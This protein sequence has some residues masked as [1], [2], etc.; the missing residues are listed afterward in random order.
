MTPSEI[1]A[2]AK[3][4]WL[5]TF[6]KAKRS[7]QYD[8]NFVTYIES[9]ENAAKQEVIEHLQPWLHIL[10]DSIQWLANL[11]GILNRMNSEKKLDSA[12]QSIW[13]LIGASCAHAVAVRR[14]VLSGLDTSARAI[15]R[16]L[17][18]HLCASLVF[19]HK[20]E[21]GAQFHQCAD[22][23]TAAQFWYKHL[24][25]RALKKHLNAIE[26]SVGLDLGF[27][28]E[29]R[30][31]R[32]REIESFSQAIH[33]SY[34][35]AAFSTITM[36]PSD[37]D[38]VGPAFVGMASINSKRTL[39][40]S[41]KSIWHFSCFGFLMLFNEHESHPPVIQLDE[42]DEMHQMTVVGRRVLQVLNQRYWEYECPKAQ[43]T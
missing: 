16:V 38:N 40:F 9:R 18:E 17:D 6:D 35:G 20:R 36:S 15:A 25:T 29:M 10:E 32:E 26:R 5:F 31:W 41:C 27:S 13:A 14:L 30:A 21:L 24:N 7:S 43:V 34:L 37:P 28:Q 1:R 11:A 22:D 2:L 4:E 8:E 3:E 23:D 33:P 39:N 19:L 12:Q 42:E